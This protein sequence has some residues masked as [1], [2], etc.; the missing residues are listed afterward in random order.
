MCIHADCL[1]PHMPGGGGVVGLQKDAHMLLLRFYSPSTVETLKD[2]YEKA[3]FFV[4]DEYGKSGK[5]NNGPEFDKDV[6]Y[7]DT[8]SC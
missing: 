3:T 5:N 2:G 8:Y 6:L 1:S 7:L 4:K